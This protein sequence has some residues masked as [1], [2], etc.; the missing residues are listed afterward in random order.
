M[1][2]SSR[3]GDGS[4]TSYSS[5]PGST[6]SP[7]PTHR[8]AITPAI[9]DRTRGA[10][11]SVPEIRGPVEIVP[12]LTTRKSSGASVTGGVEASAEAGGLPPP[13]LQPLA[14]LAA[15]VRVRVIASQ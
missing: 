9:G 5:A 12:R 4:I 11:D 2:S 14:A 10:P 8:F 7:L 6:T 3:I 1:L 15:S 13:R